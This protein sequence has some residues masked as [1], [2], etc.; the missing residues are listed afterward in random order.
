MTIANKEIQYS[1]GL[2]DAHSLNLNRKEGNLQTMIAGEDHGEE[3]KVSDDDEQAYSPGLFLAPRTTLEEAPSRSSKEAGADVSKNTAREGDIEAGLSTPMPPNTFSD[4]DKGDDTETRASYRS[5]RSAA[6]GMDGSEDLSVYT[7]NKNN[8]QASLKS[9]HSAKASISSKPKSESA[10]ARDDD[11]T[12]MSIEVIAPV[13]E[14]IG[15]C[16][17][18]KTPTIEVIDGKIQDMVDAQ[19]RQGHPKQQENLPTREIIRQ[20]SR[21]VPQEAQ[22]QTTLPGLVVV[23]GI[24]RSRTAPTNPFRSDATSSSTG[25]S[26]YT[27]GQDASTMT[28]ETFLAERDRATEDVDPEAPRQEATPDYD[29]YHYYHTREDASIGHSTITSLTRDTVFK[30]EES[31]ELLFSNELMTG[32]NVSYVTPP[33]E[34]AK[35]QKPDTPSTIRS[36]AVTKE[37]EDGEDYET[38]AETTGRWKF[39]Q[40]ATRDPTVQCLV[41]LACVCAVILFFL[42]AVIIVITSEDIGLDFDLKK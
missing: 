16:S 32:E 33:G 4:I 28:K 42:V 20:L 5:K 6:T 2:A 3:K 34:K 27:A 24:R 30:T 39:L 40:N 37:G 19:V 21:V 31:D 17:V 9:L 22:M 14:A 35:G 11:G 29:E 10:P 25:S 23:H 1:L 41:T 13:E 36:G 18:T 15:S 8:D 26:L 7:T 12:Y 38:V